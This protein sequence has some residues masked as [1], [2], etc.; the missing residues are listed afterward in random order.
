M[1]K[2]GSFVLV[3]LLVIVMVFAGGI[4]GYSRWGRTLVIEDVDYLDHGI[5]ERYRQKENTY[6]LFKK[7]DQ[8]EVLHIDEADIGNYDKDLYEVLFVPGGESLDYIVGYFRGWESIDGSNDLYLMLDKG[9]VVTKYRVILDT[10][11]P[12]ALTRT[13]YAVENVGLFKGSHTQKVSVFDPIPYKVGIE[14][15][16][17]EIKNGDVLVL[18]PKL[19]RQKDIMIDDSGVTVLEMVALRR[20]FGIL[21][22]NFGILF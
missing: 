1:N 15:I 13:T 21:E 5:G 18:A 8:T 14:Q 3:F 22:F 12:Q 20:A 16:K 10:H 11:I 17:K 7:D 6:T 9:D 2:F 4:W 19:V